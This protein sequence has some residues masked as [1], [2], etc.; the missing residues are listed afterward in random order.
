MWTPDHDGI[1]T[2]AIN[3]EN[4]EIFVNDADE[5]DFENDSKFYIAIT[6]FDGVNISI[7]RVVTIY[8]DN[9]EDETPVITPGQVFYLNEDAVRRTL[10][11]VPEAKDRDA[12]IV[13]LQNWTILNNPDSDGDGR[14]AFN[15]D[16]ETGEIT[17]ND[18][19]DID[20]EAN[21][22]I[23]LEITVSDGTNTSLTE[24]VTITNQQSSWGS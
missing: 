11:G 6:V 2:F 22:K 5:I 8:I 24:I 15:I 23:E 18:T 4:G 20:Y 7:P 9:L 14:P 13:I 1:M 19:D 16:D 12:G 21:N 10:V 3:P 17:V